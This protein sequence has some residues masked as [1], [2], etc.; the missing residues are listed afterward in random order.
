MSTSSV[1]R[2]G[3]GKTAVARA[4]ILRFGPPGPRPRCDMF[5]GQTIVTDTPHSRAELGFSAHFMMQLDIEDLERF[6]PVR[7]I[8]VARSR[9]RALGETGP[10]DLTVPDG[11]TGDFGVGDWVLADGDAVVR[12]LTP[13]A[14]L[15]RRAAGTDRA[16][17]IIASNLNTLFVVTSCNADFNPARLERYLALAAEADVTPVVIVTKADLVAD[18]DH[19]ADRAR[20]LMAGLEVL[21]LDATGAD[22][23]DR[24]APWI[25]VGQT[26]ALVGSSGVGKTTLLNALTG[27]AAETRDIRADDAKGR[28]TTTAR[29][30]HR[31]A[32][33]GWVIDT[34]GMRALRLHDTGEGVAA[35]FADVADLAARCRFSDCA[36]ETEPGCAVQAAIADGG[37]DPGRLTRWR[38]LMREDRHNSETVAEARARAK[39][40][41]K[42]VSRI[43]ED[44]RTRK[45]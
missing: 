30:M 8:A 37:L 12:R 45:G 36:H 29:S 41:G 25:G 1:G 43:Q 2:I 39:A 11:S 32:G 33:G 9:L 3:A 20:V 34:P 38:K 44:S 15:S 7:I 16:T 5:K 21:T 6:E 4:Q 28:H 31:I 40:F 22:V 19:F 23:V 13:F 10:R 26:V 14:E 17:Q 24:L 18:A 35:V 42:M 27:A